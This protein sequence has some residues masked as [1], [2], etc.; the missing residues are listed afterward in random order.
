MVDE[1]HSEKLK[2]IRRWL[3]ERPQI[4]AAWLFGSVARGTARPD[5]DLDIA[6][7]T[8]AAGQ[9]HV[10]SLKQR[11]AWA[12]SLAEALAM[13]PEQVDLIVLN[14]APP[15]LVHAVLKEGALLVDRAPQQRVLFQERAL[16][17]YI[18]AA[19]LR[20]EAMRERARRFGVDWPR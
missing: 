17:R 11:L 16:H 12:L 9:T 14:E 10:A 7:L 15:L 18:V 5:S 13:R 19:R 8:E 1:S 3:D 2:F 4:V 20:D 6:L